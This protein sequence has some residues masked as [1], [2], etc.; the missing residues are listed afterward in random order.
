VQEV[1]ANQAFERLAAG[2]AIG[3]D[4]REDFEWQAGRAD[5]PNMVF[6]P[7]SNFDPAKL[8]PDKPIIFICRS[9]NR[10]GQVT[11]HLSS[12][13]LDVS[14]MSGGMQSWEAAGLPMAADIGDPYVA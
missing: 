1:T 8:P 6:N 13:G 4:V 3:I 14:N 9:G 2:E 12:F 5:A 11:E 10:S 7:L